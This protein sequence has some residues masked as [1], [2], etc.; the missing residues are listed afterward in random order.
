MTQISPSTQVK[1]PREGK[2]KKDQPFFL[3]GCL[4]YDT[5]PQ[6]SKDRGHLALVE[7]GTPSIPDV[8]ATLEKAAYSL[9]LTCLL[10]MFSVTILPSNR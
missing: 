7:G 9:L 5:N 1:T 2:I 3:I 4:R 8:A 10:A 6:P